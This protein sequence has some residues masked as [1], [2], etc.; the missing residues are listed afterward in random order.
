VFPGI[1]MK[2]LYADPATGMST[3]LFKMA[4]GAV[5]PLHEH[6]GV[7]QTYVLS[8]SLVDAEGAATEGNFVWRP[9][10]SVHVARAPHGAVF[11]SVFTQPNRFATGERFYT[12]T[13]S[14]HAAQGKAR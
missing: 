5:V 4:P 3:I 14:D 13:A 11:L 6:M 8:G 7:E 1:E 9:G 2:I 12:E 10:G